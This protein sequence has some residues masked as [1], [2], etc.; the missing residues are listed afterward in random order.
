[1]SR[2]KR[3]VSAGLLATLFSANYTAGA[4]AASVEPGVT[5]ALKK[6][7]IEVS[8]TVKDKAPLVEKYLLDGR[9][10]EGDVALSNH[11]KEHASDDQAR[12]GLGVLQFLRAVEGLGQSLTRYGVRTHNNSGFVLP[13]LRLPATTNENCKKIDYLKLREIVDTFQ[14]QLMKAE[15]TLAPISDG[16]VKLPLHFGM[17]KLDLNGTG[18]QL[19]QLRSPL[20]NQSAQFDH[21]STKQSHIA[22]NS[23]DNRSLWKVYAKLTN[24]TNIPVEKAEKFFIKFD[25]GDV[26]WLRGYCHLLSSVC[27]IYLAHDSKDLFDRTAHL[28]FTKVDSPYAFLSKAKPIRSIGGGDLEVFDLIAFVHLLRCDVVEPKRMASA[29]NH[30]QAV[31]DQ[32]RETWKWIMAEEDDDHEWLPN[33]RQTGVI[34]NARVTEQM[35]VAWASIMTESEKILS[36]ELL[37]PFWRGSE[38]DRRGINLRKVFLE[39]RQFDLVLWVQGSAAA[40]YL[41][42]GKLTKG[43]TWRDLRGEFGSHFPGF[44]LW[45]N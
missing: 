9:L 38:S 20:P 14:K 45:F 42:E 25:R 44:A 10:N 8:A 33:P 12:F 26:H 21:D 41:E 30:L 3:A 40:P 27:D 16:D 17:I 37:I 35:V 19:H 22:E 29:L 36:G 11:L 4:L 18:H 5:S 1:M 15:A 7:V 31:I 2:F 24:N 6:E 32:S 39:P 23:D 34:P 28:F 43:R 13:F